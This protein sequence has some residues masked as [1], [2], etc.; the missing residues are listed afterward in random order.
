M[1]GEFSEP[2]RDNSEPERDNDGDPD[3]TDATDETR[4]DDELPSGLAEAGRDQVLH[5]GDEE[6]PVE[7]VLDVLGTLEPGETLDVVSPMALVPLYD[8]LDELGWQYEAVRTGADDWL[9]RISVEETDGDSGELLRRPRRERLP[10]DD[11]DR[12]R[13]K[14]DSSER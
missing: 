1:R 14:T 3:R 13:R 9:I 8:R 11:A 6:E 12:F 7:A 5:V 4:E 2:E 10:P